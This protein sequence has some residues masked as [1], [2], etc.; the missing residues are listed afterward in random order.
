LAAAIERG[1]TDG[2]VSYSPTTLAHYATAA[3]E[4]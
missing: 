4:Y 1:D 3:Y 2:I